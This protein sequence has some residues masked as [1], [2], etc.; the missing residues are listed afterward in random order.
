MQSSAIDAIYD[1]KAPNFV[2]LQ[3]NEYGVIFGLR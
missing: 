3:E 1:F 2:F